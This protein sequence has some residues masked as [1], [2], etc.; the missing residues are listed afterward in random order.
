[1]ENYQVFRTLALLKER[2]D[3]LEGGGV[4]QNNGPSVNLDDVNARLA[5]LE[6]NP[7]IQGVTI[8]NVNECL[9]AL[10]AR[11]QP[12]I[13]D[14]NNRL[15]AV[16]ARP[17]VTLDDVISRLAALEARPSV[18]LD[19]VTGRLTA[20]EGRPDVTQRLSALELTIA[21]LNNS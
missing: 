2:V 3:K 9:A 6:R 1:M 21:S 11:I 4:V 14:I 16:E 10:E 7:T 13:D 18:T 12:T 8:N 15:A 5:A 17:Q 19:D 20:L